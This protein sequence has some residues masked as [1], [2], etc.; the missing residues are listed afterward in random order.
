MIS[1]MRA[2]PNT[3]LILI[4]GLMVGCSTTG[5]NIAGINNFDTVKD[6]VLYRGAQP[7]REGIQ[8]LKAQGVR[9]VVNLRDDPPSWEKEAVEQAG[10][11]YVSIPS[12]AHKTD[13]A[14]I[15]RFLQTMKDG[16]KPVFVHCHVG[17]DRTG[18]NVA[19]Y[20]IVEEGATRDAAIKDLHDHGYQWLF[21]PG[22]EKYLKSFDPAQYTTATT[23]PATQ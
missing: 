19:T 7:S 3:A 12:V 13:P 16:D 21:F 10:M 14:A 22:I 4:L 2:V 5:K 17:R 11:N 20:R 15:Q 9:T 18:L 6:G 1:P 23:A 8:T